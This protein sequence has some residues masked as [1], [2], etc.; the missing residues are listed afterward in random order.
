[1]E[2]VQRRPDG[3]GGAALDLTNELGTRDPNK[4]P[5]NQFRQI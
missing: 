3:H 5:D 1:M 2:L 4:S